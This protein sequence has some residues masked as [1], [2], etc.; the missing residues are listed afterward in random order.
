MFAYPPPRFLFN[1]FF[2]KAYCFGFSIL[3]LSCLWWSTCM[4]AFFFLIILFIYIIIKFLTQLTG[5]N[6]YL[7]AHYIIDCLLECVLWSFLVSIDQTFVGA[8]FPFNLA[9]STSVTMN[10]WLIYI[11]RFLLVL[12]LGIQI[13]RSFNNFFPQHW[14]IH[15]IFHFMVLK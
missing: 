4:F 5:N 1:F 2:F 8:M 14:I 10:C 11:F 15:N 9:C 3:T 6:Q 7:L 13:T 12:V